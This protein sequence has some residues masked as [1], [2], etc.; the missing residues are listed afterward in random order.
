MK[1][2]WK[3]QGCIRLLM[4]TFLDEKYST[5]EIRARVVGG[6]K[7][8]HKQTWRNLRES[9]LKDVWLFRPKWSQA[10][11]PIA[12]LAPLDS[13]SPRPRPLPSPSPAQPQGPPS[14]LRGQ[15]PYLYKT[16]PLSS[17]I[18]TRCPAIST[19]ATS[20]GEGAPLQRC[21]TER[22]HTVQDLITGGDGGGTC[23]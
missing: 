10:E 20:E 12:F 1:N 4:A 21:D 9:S 11:N 7:K 3:G 6:G 18:L 22:G 23:G 8:S 15:K 17:N 16:H 14:V 19:P 5:K 2:V 13:L